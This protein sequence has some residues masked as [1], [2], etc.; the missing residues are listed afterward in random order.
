VGLV[1]VVAPVALVGCAQEVA[2]DEVEQSIVDA[3]TEQQVTLESVDCPEALPAELDAAI[4][5]EVSVIGVNDLGA[6]VDR[7][8]VGVT[9]I[10]GEE[11]RY[12]LEPLAEGASH[13]GAG[14]GDGDG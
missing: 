2:G 5:C 3:M 14:A 6:P 11:V 12:R 10:E 8:R 9:A 7:I 13:E 1:T 4:V